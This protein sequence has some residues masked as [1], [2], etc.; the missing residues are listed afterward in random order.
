[1]TDI[2]H[3]IAKT[4]AEKSPLLKSYWKQIWDLASRSCVSQANSRAACALMDHLIRFGFLNHSE[5]VDTLQLMLSAM[6]LNGPSVFCDTALMFLTRIFNTRLHIAAGLGP[7]AVKGIC[8]WLRGLWTTG[9]PPMVLQSFV[10]Y[11]G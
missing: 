8:T 10:R 4:D 6:D 1:M 2:F 9:N 11:E 7:D 3:S 5:V